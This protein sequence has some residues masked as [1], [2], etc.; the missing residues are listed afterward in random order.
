MTWC[1]GQT[2]QS[3]WPPAQ[4]LDEALTILGQIADGL[5]RV[6]AAGIVKRRCLPVWL[7]CRAHEWRGQKGGQCGTASCFGEAK[8]TDLIGK[9]GGAARI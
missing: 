3:G 7:I 5:A 8:T 4:S 2:R 9:T 6:H 1:D